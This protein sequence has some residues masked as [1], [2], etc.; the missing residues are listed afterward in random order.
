LLQKAFNARF[1]ALKASHCYL[2]VLVATAVSAAGQK[3]NNLMELMTMRSGSVTNFSN[4]P[5]DVMEAMGADV[6]IAVDV[7]SSSD[8]VKPE[9]L[10][11]LGG[12]LGRTYSIAQRPGQVESLRRAD[13][14]IQP[15][16]AGFGAAD[17]ARVAEIIPPGEEAAR[18]HLDELSGL[19]VS[20][21]AYEDYLLR[22]RRPLPS[23]VHVREVPVTGNERVSERAIR[24][25]IRILPGDAF[26]EEALNQDTGNHGESSSGR[27][28]LALCRQ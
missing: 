18:R 15:D 28:S 16:L 17:F 1:G 20:A 5:V 19:S 14:G 9:S 11:T 12:I 25:R 13:I 4:L 10:K 7:G 21:E 3:F 27:G 24:G 8:V 2:L 26:E 22:Q 6:I 23:E